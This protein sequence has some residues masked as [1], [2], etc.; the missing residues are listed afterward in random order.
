MP[1]RPPL[2]HSMCHGSVRNRREP[3]SARQVPSLI[4][5]SPDLPVGHSCAVQLED[6][7]AALLL[8]LEEGPRAYLDRCPHRGSRLIA[9]ADVNREQQDPYM[10]ATGG[11]ILCHRHQACFE[12]H[13]GVCVSG[14]CL[15]ERLIALRVEVRQSDARQQNQP[16]LVLWDDE[17]STEA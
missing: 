15:G 6:G 13:H 4:L 11:L 10:D 17:T 3:D 12:P 8:M 16:W 5:P 1:E 7:R 9:E 14:P 2:R